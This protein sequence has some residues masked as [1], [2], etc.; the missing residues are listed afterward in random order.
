MTAPLAPSPSGH[1]G[2]TPSGP[3][4]PRATR[5]HLRPWRGETPSPPASRAPY[6]TRPCVAFGAAR[7]QGAHRAVPPV[8][9]LAA[10]EER[11]VVID[12]AH[13]DTADI[14]RSLHEPVRWGRRLFEGR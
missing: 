4:R 3:R 10:R 9:S 13:P 11:L 1:P 14:E 8:P 2:D 12:P 7:A 5:R 6:R